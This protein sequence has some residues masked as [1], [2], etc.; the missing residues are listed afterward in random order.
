M[1]TREELGALTLLVQAIRPA[2]DTRAI[3]PVLDEIAN[4]HAFNGDLALLAWAAIRTAQ[5]HDM[6]SPAAIAFDGDHWKPGNQ[7]GPTAAQRAETRRELEIR[8]QEIDRCEWCDPYGRLEGGVLLLPRHRPRHPSTPSHSTRSPSTS[9]HPTHHRERT[10]RSMTTRTRR[11]IVRPRPHRHGRHDQR[12]TIHRHHL[13]HQD[14]AN[15]STHTTQ[16]DSTPA[17]S[18]HTPGW[19]VA[20]QTAA[21]NATAHGKQAQPVNCRPCLDHPRAR[22]NGMTNHEARTGRA[23]PTAWTTAAASMSEPS[24]DL[25]AAEYWLS[26]RR[27]LGQ[28]TRHHRQRSHHI[29]R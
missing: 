24:D 23:H 18:A 2:W 28:R 27:T 7:T 29:G 17:S 22:A 19:S 3:R 9:S 6:R 14:S 4:R 11:A 12:P 10:R 5:N 8:Y 13:P 25:T 16:P 20:N 21:H 1:I 26:Q 15:A